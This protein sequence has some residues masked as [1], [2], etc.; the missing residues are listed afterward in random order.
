MSYRD[1]GYDSFMRK[2]IISLDSEESELNRKIKSAVSNL[3]FMINPTT[4]IEFSSTDENT[5]AWS[6]GTIYFA[7]GSKSGQIVAGNTGT[8]TGVTFIYYDRNH[9]GELLTTTDHSHSVGTSRFLLAIADVGATG[10]SCKIIPSIGA[11]LVV[12]DITAEQI[13]ANTIDTSLLTVGSL[14]FVSTLAW[15]AT[16]ANTASWE[17]GTIV[18]SD[19]TSYS[20]SAGNTGN[21]LATTYV[22]LDTDT[23]TTVLQTTSTASGSTGSNKLLLAIVQLGATGSKC[24]IDVIN[25]NGTTIDGDRIT[26]GKVQSSDGKTYFDLDGDVII[27]NDGTNDRVLIGYQSGGF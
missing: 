26:T 22:Y 8:M 13:T 5:A 27:M 11:G 20:I 1:L 19:G 24:I 12:S 10:K 18:T 3:Q 15:T 21:I 9:D 17:S 25:S 14:S 2:E 16:D 6:T 23:S 4:D 7:D